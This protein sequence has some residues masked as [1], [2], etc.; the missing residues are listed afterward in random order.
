MF[1]RTCGLRC[2]SCHQSPG[3]SAAAIV[4]IALGIGASVTIYSF[5]H[6]VLFRRLDVPDADRLVHHKILACR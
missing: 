6:A 2:G 3:L 5:A 4:T 1:F